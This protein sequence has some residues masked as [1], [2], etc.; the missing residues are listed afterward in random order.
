MSPHRH[1]PG[2]DSRTRATQLAGRILLAC[3]LLIPGLLAS[4]TDSL[5]HTKSSSYSRLAP[6]SDGADLRVRMPLLELTRFPPDHDWPGYLATHLVVRAGEELCPPTTPTRLAETAPGWAVFR[7]SVT[8][9]GDEPLSI[10]SRIFAD[11]LSN[12]LHFARV[13][14]AEQGIREQVLV[15]ASPRWSLAPEAEES[16]GESLGGYFLLGVEHILSG[17]DHLAFVA[18]LLLLAHSLREVATLVTSFTLA[19]SLTLALAVL[20]I[21]R[22][23]GA[24]VEILIGFSIALV[25]AEN[26]WILAGQDRRIPAVFVASLITAGLLAG[27]GSG[28]LGPLAWA[29]LALFSFCHFGLLRDRTG[30]GAWLRALVAF[31]FGLVHGFGFAGI[32]MEI[33]LPAQRL[34]PALLGFNLGVEAG[35]LG[36]VL[37]VWPALRVLATMKQGQPYL[38]LAETGSAV[39]AGLGVYWVV[40]RNWG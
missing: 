38:R 3:L 1:D 36:V 7:W 9:P 2:G 37:L 28:T 8:C 23:E 26:A 11:V 30:G 12:H 34:V 10:E 39:I 33:E 31:A 35:Q 22:P 40:S 27:L 18:A 29:G 4:A 21:L 16:I 6:T 24:A 25:A 17:W 5:A 14:D 32:L 20:G 19:H 13:R 15:A